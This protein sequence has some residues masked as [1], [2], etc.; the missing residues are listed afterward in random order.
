VVGMILPA[1]RTKYIIGLT[2]S[3][4]AFKMD[5][6]CKPG[7]NDGTATLQACGVLELL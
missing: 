7:W 1:Q 5:R 6:R 4:Q 2:H 3:E